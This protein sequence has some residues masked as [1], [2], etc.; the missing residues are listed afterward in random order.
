M[1][2]D[3]FGNGL[4]GD[5]IGSRLKNVKNEEI[6][7]DKVIIYKNNNEIQSTPITST[8]QQVLNSVSLDELKTLLLQQTQ[9]AIVYSNT[10]GQREINYH[11]KTVD[12]D[13]IDS[14]NLQ[15]QIKEG[16]VNCINNCSV[17]TNNVSYGKLAVKT[18]PNAVYTGN[19]AWTDDYFT[20]GEVDRRYID[21]AG[22]SANKY[23][24]CVGIGVN[25]N[26]N[27]ALS[28]AIIKCIEPS[29]AWRP[30]HISAS[31]IEFDFSGTNKMYI[32]GNI[33]V[34]TKILPS[35]NATHDIGADTDAGSGVIGGTQVSQWFRNGFFTNI[36]SNNVLITSDKTLK[37][38]ITD[39]TYGLN[40]ILQ[41]QPKQYQYINNSNGRIHWG[42]LAQHIRELN[43]N[44]KLSVW[45]LRP[46]GK[47]QLNYTEFIAV[48]CKAIQELNEKIK[49]P[50]IN[51]DGEQLDLTPIYKRL[52]KIEN[53]LSNKEEPLI[54]DKGDA[55]IN[56]QTPINTRINE[57][58]DIIEEKLNSKDTSDDESD[59]HFNIMEDLQAKN[60]QLEQRLSKLE[61]QYKKLTTAINKILKTNN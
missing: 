11:I 61:K 52:D 16:V 1:S 50:I 20:V 14:S 27:P 41:L 34:S 2:I 47:Q 35:A 5:N 43:Q 28:Y 13:P 9:E 38:N 60:F 3:I 33:V 19:S 58:L 21:G 18:N 25:V 45:G 30:I 8:G 32:R 6:T 46:N 54:E 23:G 4:S 12:L 56:F 44:D 48:I 22:T 36:Y 15:L 51:I 40:Y 42:F 39:L 55:L 7:Q 31:S 26:A 57:R 53:E 17:G 10:D 37:Q 49:Q 24:L 59:G 29:N